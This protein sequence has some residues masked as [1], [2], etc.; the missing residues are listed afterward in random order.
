VPIITSFAAGSTRGLGQFRRVVFGEA[1]AGATGD[2]SFKYVTLLLSGN[3]TNNDNNNVFRDSS[4]N[5]FTVTRN[6]N[7]T[8]GTF[9]PY[10]NNWS[11]YFDGSATYLSVPTNSAFVFGTGDFT[12]EA[13]VYMTATPGGTGG[14]I[15]GMHNNGVTAQ[16]IIIV[17]EGSTIFYTQIPGTGSVSRI[18]VAAIPLNTWT[19]L[20]MTRSGTT[21]RGFVNGFLVGSTSN[22]LNLTDPSVPV[23]IGADNDGSD[24]RFTGYISNVRVVKGTALYTASFTPSS[25]P[26]TAVSGTSLLT[27]HLPY[28]KDSSTNNFAVTRNGNVSV[29]KFSQFTSNT[30]YSAN[31]I[32]GSVYMD[33]TGDYL[34]TPA[35]TAYVNNGSTNLTIEAWVYCTSAGYWYLHDQGSG[36]A[37]AIAIN[38]SATGGYIYWYSP[39]FGYLTSTPSNL[40]LPINSWIH[41]AFVRNGS[42]TAVYVN[43][44]SVQTGTNSAAYGINGTF[45]IGRYAG[46]AGYNFPGY[47][48]DFRY[49]NGTAVYTSNFT[50]PTAPL[51]NI[52]NTSLLYNFTNAGIADSAMMNDLETVG[53]AKI[54]TSVSKF[55]GSS[56]AFDGTGDYVLSNMATTD[57]YA[58]GRGDFTIEMWVYFVA[59]PSSGD[60]DNL[61]DFRPNGVNGLYPTIY[62]DGTA[63]TLR[64]LT[65]SADKITGST[66]ISTSTWY[67]VAVTRSGTST[68]MFLNGTQEGSTYTDSN[69]Y[70]NAT[71]RPIIAANGYLNGG[72]GL[73]N[74]YID[75]LRITKGV[76]RYTANF[77]P[78]TAA[79][80]TSGA[81]SSTVPSFVEYLV[82]AGGAGGG[83]GSS[84]GGYTGGGG[85]GAGGMRMGYIDIVSGISYNVTVGAGGSAGGTA[86]VGSNG[87]NSV[88]GTVSSRGGGRGSNGAGIAYDPSGGGGGGAGGSG[89]GSGYRFTVGGAAATGQGNTG[90]FA[91][92]G[93]QGSGGGGGAGAVGGNG[94]NSPTCYT[95]GNGGNGLA[96]SITGTPVTYAGGG[97]AGGLG[98]GGYNGRGGTGGTGG[99]GTG[100]GNNGVYTTPGGNATAGTTNLGGGGGGGARNV[101]GNPA[102]LGAAGGSGV[103]VIRYA[104]S[105]A[106]AASTTGSPEA[107]T[108]DGFRIYRWTGS[109]S[110]T[111]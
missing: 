45:D 111:F 29:V 106:A 23:T 107:T 89:G 103:V 22:S 109:G 27:C 90:G 50:P 60:F 87:T 7:P 43:G 52:N 85:G 66:T 79:L 82:V 83:G 1:A 15:I 18:D 21:M 5:N 38:F 6:G 2:A 42:S 19:H 86:S 73:L 51:T 70:I 39:A 32:G 108:A 36:N 34:Q 98:D 54:S 46:G 110:I 75:D 53:D 105:F 20:A 3:G 91:G 59:L 63:K 88:F 100:A 81:V 13:W 61:I 78:P 96:S 33:G 62:V 17:Y 14:Q 58:F 74:G 77:T 99:G 40:N 56:M 97:G 64:Y 48:C 67:H 102:A 37:A 95:G 31:T 41:L 57:L 26:L 8:Q 65:D 68:K 76:A 24:C 101:P 104:D 44:V 80:P 16:W 9:S 25:S 92:P 28:L 30:A 11:N 4:N 55:G 47:I 93:E 71:Q 94:S 12:V 72:G 49:V 84:I 35:S 69:V 10:G